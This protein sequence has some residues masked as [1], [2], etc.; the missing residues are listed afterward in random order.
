MSMSTTAANLDSDQLIT[1]LSQQRDLYRKLRDL[2]DK[3]RSMIAGDHP[4]L[5]LGI[6][7]ERQDLVSALARLNDELAPFRRHWDTM[8]AGL[9]NERRTQASDLLQEINSL[10]R[11]IL[12]TDQEDGALLSARRQVIAAQIAGATGGQ[13]ANAAYARQAGAPAGRTAADMTG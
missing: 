4:E 11:V 3:Q 13:V 5:L 10:L 12:R 1:L 9:P 8:Y 2:S 7:R 6:L